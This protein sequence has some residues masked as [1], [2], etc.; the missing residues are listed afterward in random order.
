MPRDWVGLTRLVQSA[1]VFAT[2]AGRSDTHA[3]GKFDNSNDTLTG[4]DHAIRQLIDQDTAIIMKRS[5][6]T[7]YGDAFREVLCSF[8]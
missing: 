5:A 4:C 8:G 6:N 7:A 1:R 2:A 3:H